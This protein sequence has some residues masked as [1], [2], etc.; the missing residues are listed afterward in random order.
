MQGGNFSYHIAQQMQC[1][2][3]FF[4]IITLIAQLNV[5]NL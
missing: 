1:S 2:R 3:D 5:D 4:H